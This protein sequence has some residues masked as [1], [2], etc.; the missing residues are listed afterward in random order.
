MK[1]VNTDGLQYAIA[2]IISLISEG[3][4]WVVNKELKMRK[5]TFIHH[6]RSSG[7]DSRDKNNS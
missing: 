3:Y 5:F 7:N 4:L 6:S 2:I 1:L